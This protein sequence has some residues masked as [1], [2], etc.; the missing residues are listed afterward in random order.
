[1]NPI[2]IIIVHVFLFVGM[3]TKGM[4]ANELSCLAG[5]VFCPELNAW[6]Y[7]FYFSLSHTKVICHAYN[8]I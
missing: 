7:S 2:N 5:K 1:M 3:A 8:V 4:L 6:Y